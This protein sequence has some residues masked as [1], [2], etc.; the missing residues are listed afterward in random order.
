M[1]KSRP[2]ID[3]ASTGLEL[4]SDWLRV[5]QE[6]KMAGLSICDATNCFC[7]RPGINLSLIIIYSR[8]KSICFSIQKEKDYSRHVDE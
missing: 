5:A 1:S 2:I 4:F 7:R 3:Q 6:P 8:V